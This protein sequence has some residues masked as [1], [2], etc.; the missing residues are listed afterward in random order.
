MSVSKTEIKTIADLIKVL[1]PL[2]NKKL[3]GLDFDYTEYGGDEQSD[4][5]DTVGVMDY[6]ESVWVTFNPF[7]GDTFRKVEV[8]ETKEIED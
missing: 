4:D 6:G 8:G 7:R 5:I 3:D 2:K 1:E